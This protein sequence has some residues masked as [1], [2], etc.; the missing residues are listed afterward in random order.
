V[1][2]PWTEEQLHDIEEL[3]ETKRLHRRDFTSSSFDFTASNRRKPTSPSSAVLDTDTTAAE[4]ELRRY[5]GNLNRIHDEVQRTGMPWDLDDPD[6]RRSSPTDPITDTGEVENI[7]YQMVS[8]HMRTS[9]GLH[10][11]SSSEPLPRPDNLRRPE[12][13]PLRDR[14]YDYHLLADLFGHDWHLD[15][16]DFE[17]QEKNL[18]PD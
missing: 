3:Q 10:S 13:L 11:Q 6:N 9:S 5:F 17:H 4:R 2:G 7:T 15:S 12:D 14:G 18:G 8:C 16:A 1:S